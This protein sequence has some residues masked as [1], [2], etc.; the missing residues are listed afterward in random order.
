MY[1]VSEQL[2]QPQEE[3]Y[4]GYRNSW[5]KSSSS[6]RNS[7]MSDRNSSTSSSVRLHQ[8]QKQPQRLQK[9]SFIAKL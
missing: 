8:L 6:G 9:Q 4:I 7:C 5:E 1:V 2:H 3:L